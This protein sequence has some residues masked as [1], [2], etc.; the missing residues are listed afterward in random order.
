MD[1]TKRAV[2][3][4]RDGTINVDPGYLDRPEALI[5]LDGAVEA[6]VRL[7]SLGFRLFVVTNQSG[8]GRGLFTEA[9]LGAIHRRLGEVI[10]PA[11][12]EEFASCLHRPE[13]GCEC[14]KPSA[15]LILDLAARH[16]VDVNQSYMVGDKLSDVMAGQNAGVKESVLVLTGYGESERAAVEAQLGMASERGGGAR[17]FRDLRAFSVWLE[18]LEGERG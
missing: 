9:T 2:F 3:L 5:L 1:N 8:V 17:V 10:A 12:I 4:D 13:E 14:R 7:Q 6:L 11:V 18:N 16:G 15:K